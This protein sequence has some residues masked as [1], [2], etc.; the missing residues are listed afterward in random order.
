MLL[1]YVLVIIILDERIES[2]ICIEKQKKNLLILFK[3]SKK[4]RKTVLMNKNVIKHI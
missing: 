1:N 2:A 3:M 4:E